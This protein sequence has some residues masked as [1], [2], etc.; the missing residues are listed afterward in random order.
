MLFCYLSF[1]DLL[2][3]CYIILI[4]SFPHLQSLSLQMSTL[5]KK[6]LQPLLV[7]YGDCLQEL[8]I[9]IRHE[10]HHEPDVVLDL[11][12]VF[13]MCTKLITFHL[14]GTIACIDSLTTCNY[15]HFKYVCFLY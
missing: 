11:F 15:D 9:E 3:I 2:L 7:H 10:N 1:F 5:D 4:S 12:Y 14:Q 13:H 6:F 8:K